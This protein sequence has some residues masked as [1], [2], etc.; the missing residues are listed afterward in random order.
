MNQKK[1]PELELRCD[2]HDPKC[3]VIIQYDTEDDELLF[4]G[5]T[6]NGGLFQRIKRAWR[7]LWADY[8]DAFL[9]TVIPGEEASRR[10]F[11]FVGEVRNYLDSLAKD[12]LTKDKL[13][14]SDD[15]MK[16]TKKEELND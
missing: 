11:L 8:D 15:G 2:C 10:I 14:Y 3:S 7:M 9:N 1:M 4:W 13:I 6:Y 12:K 16:A 5:R